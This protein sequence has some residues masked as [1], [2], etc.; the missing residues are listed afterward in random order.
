MKKKK[1]LFVNEFSQLST[2]FSTY[3]NEVMKRLY[4]TGKYELAEQASYCSADDPRIFD[5]PWKVYP[6]MPSQQDKGAWDQFNSIRTAQFGSLSITNVLLDYKPD[7]VCSWRDNWMDEFLLTS[8]YRP[9]FKWA[10]MA[11]IDGEPQKPEWLDNYKRVDYLLTYSEWAAN[12]VTSNGV[13]VAG[14]HQPGTDI[15]I[16]KPPISKFAAKEAVGLNPDWIIIQTVMRNQP[17]KLYP[18]LFKAFSRYI[19]LC[20]EN[21]KDELAAK[22]YLHIHCALR[23]VGW[24]LAQEIKNYHLSHK[25]LFTYQDKITGNAYLS[26]YKGDPAWSRE[27]NQKSSSTT[28][29]GQ[30]VTREILSK[31]M[32][33]ADLYIQYSIC[34]DGDT[35]ITTNNGY[36]KISEIKIGDVVLTHKNR[37][38]KVLNTF[39][40]K[41]IGRNIYKITG[42]SGN[43]D[44]IC[45]GNHPLYCIQKSGDSKISLREQLPE[46]KF[47]PAEQLNIG[48]IIISNIDQQINDIEKID[49]AKY[50]SGDQYI[51]NDEKIIVKSGKTYDRF[52][53]L[54]NE[55]CKFLGMFIGDGSCS[56]NCV[57]ITCGNQENENISL[58]NDIMASS[59]IWY[60]FL[61]YICYNDDGKIIPE[62][63]LKLPLEKQKAFVYGLILADGHQTNVEHKGIVFNNTSKNVIQNLQRMLDRLS[64]VYNSHWR[65]RKNDDVKDGCSRQPICQLEIRK[66]LFED[67]INI[68]RNNTR[69]FF[70]NGQKFIQIKNIEKIEYTKE[71]VYN[72]EVE[73]DNSYVG[74]TYVIKN[75]EGFGMPVIDAKACGTPVIGIPYSATAELVTEPGGIPLKIAGWRQESIQETSQRRCEPD[76]EYTAREFYKFFTAPQSYRNDLGK[77]A[78]DIVVKKYGWDGCAKKWEN[79]LDSIEIPDITETWLS[80]SKIHQPIT[81]NIPGNI[82]NESF[83]GWCYQNI[84]GRP[85]L[86]K[87]DTYMSAIDRLNTGQINK[88]GFVKECLEICNNYNR[89]EQ[90]RYNLV[91]GI[92]P[93]GGILYA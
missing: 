8:P 40:N 54:D 71:N 55:F 5:V 66:G 89:A 87:Y 30:G 6:V 7:I 51:I 2:G 58:S 45:T 21:G 36:K 20:K 42:S 86:L 72:I 67:N 56:K 69:N 25:V 80:Q 11:T 29:T 26:F 14:T 75:C 31:I 22:T 82:S 49:L 43:G 73:E 1:I 48:D 39:E 44:L 93:K 62:F 23:D 9:Y 10:W 34:L 3:G 57:K 37:Y 81:Q 59:C 65:D 77:D 15:N 41:V 38:R 47:I 4:A 79:L 88:E 32:Q 50:I 91:N 92:K 46:P 33:A 19:E 12:L 13:R 68:D 78:R 52:V 35:E 64:I 16:F 61:K 76:N 90:H 18:E 83:I 24:D 17:R 28:N 70:H 60:E 84:I 74:N 27:T 63:I 85:W 53:T